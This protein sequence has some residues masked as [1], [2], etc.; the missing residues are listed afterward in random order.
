MINIKELRIGNKVNAFYDDNCVV[1][2]TFIETVAHIQQRKLM[3]EEDKHWV[4][5]ENYS[6]IPLTAE[7]LEK[8]KFE[9]WDRDTMKYTYKIKA[10]EF[11]YLL[12]NIYDGSCAILHI[13]HGC[14]A[15]FGKIFHL[16]QLQN[17]F[18]FISSTELEIS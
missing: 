1:K 7:L 6:P 8:Y 16:H 17:L 18:Y 15:D 2:G 9:L 11:I 12:I 5:I 10:G 13:N 4:D 14:S 3:T